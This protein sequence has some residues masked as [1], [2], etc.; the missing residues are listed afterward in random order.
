M[1]D[2]RPV[3]L[4]LRELIAEAIIDGRY[5]EGDMLPS[6]RAF[7]AEQ[8]ANPLTVAKAY[9]QF[10]TDG[11]IRVQRGVG[12]FV[13][14]GAADK[15]LVAERAQFLDEEWPQIRAKMKRLGLEQALQIVAARAARHR[16]PIET[17]PLA[18]AHGRVLGEDVRT[19][20]PLPPFANSAMD[21][22]ALRGADL[23][24][25]GAREFTLIGD[26]FAGATS[27][28]E[29]GEGQCVRI[30]TGAPMPIGADTVVIKENVSVE[31]E[32]VRVKAGESVDYALEPSRHA[33]L[34]PAV[35]TVEVNGVKL[36]ARDGAA[37]TDLSS[38]TIKALE[39]AELVL[40]D[41]A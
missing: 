29:V 5:G 16:L 12:M 28:P 19:A 31:G 38:L 2:N 39:D 10:Q 17:V 24:E 8:G 21:G 3:Y 37:I 33:Y 11:L 7:A 30:T 27:A 4:R 9:Q 32:R 18:D 35:G 36:N 14:E 34:V 41:A 23:P 22:F 15:L 40:V 13:R 20:H 1:S 25:G 6:V 26:V